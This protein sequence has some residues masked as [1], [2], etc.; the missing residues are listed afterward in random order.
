MDDQEPLHMVVEYVDEERE[1]NGQKRLM[2]QRE[3]VIALDLA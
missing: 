1:D 3:D 2:E